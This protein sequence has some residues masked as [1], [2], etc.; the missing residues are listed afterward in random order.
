MPYKDRAARLAY[1]KAYRNRP[2]EKVRRRRERPF[3]DMA[4]H[5]NKRADLYQRPG[6]LRYQSVLTVFAR[7][8]GAC[9]YCGSHRLLGL[10][11]R[12]ALSN[13]G[14]NTIG[15]VAVCCRPCNSSKWRQD[16]P[17]KW[18][19]SYESCKGCGS[20]EKK[21]IAKGF[22]NACYLRNRKAISATGS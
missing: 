10:D 16:A 14:D 5:A 1:Y 7:D 2:S 6:V 20:S 19:R 11:H 12:L 9:V 21:H 4:K 15:N 18:A 17:W 8:S 22:C 3:W 13:G